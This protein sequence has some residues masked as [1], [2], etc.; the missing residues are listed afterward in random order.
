MFSVIDLNDGNLW[1]ANWERLSAD[2]RSVY[3]LPE[4]YSVYE[5][6]GHGKAFC[7]VFEGEG[8]LL[9]YPFLKKKIILDGLQEGYFDIEG[10]YGLNGA[11]CSALSAIDHERFIQL[12][13]N[14]C[15]NEKIIAEFTRINPLLKTDCLGH[16]NQSLANQVVFV[17]LLCPNLLYDSY[18]HSV[19]KGINKAARLGVSVESYDS[20]SLPSVY[21]DAF[22]HVYH[23]TMDRKNAGYYYY[24]S[25]DYFDFI[26]TL[27][28]NNARWFFSLIAGEIVSVELVLFDEKFCYSFLGGTLPEQFST[29]ANTILKHEIITHFQKVGLIAF[30]LGGGVSSFDGIYKYKK[31]FA[32]NVSCDFYIGKKV[33]CDDIYNLAVSQWERSNPEKIETYKNYFLKYR[34]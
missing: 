19:R 1:R 13:N 26:K 5:K 10:A 15:I 11:G 16:L 8:G 29:G 22:I 21:F 34:C 23:A 7:C 24:F 6:C 9:L 28:G 3:L 32:K 33:H 31:S 25:S 30:F 2:Q 4:Y 20:A 27:V 17:D 12:W 18:E 14:Y